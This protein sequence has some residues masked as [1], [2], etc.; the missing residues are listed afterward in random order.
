MKVKCISNKPINEFAGLGLSY[1]IEGE[2]YTIAET[3]ISKQTGRRFYKLEELDYLNDGWGFYSAQR[4]M[5][6]HL[7]SENGVHK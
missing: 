7:M 6:V 2:V 5:P 4:F 1:L 3:F